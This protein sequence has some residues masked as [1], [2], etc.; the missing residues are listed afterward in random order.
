MI[1]STSLSPTPSAGSSTF[2][3]LRQYLIKWM[4]MLVYP[5]SP[6]QSS[7]LLI[8]GLSLIPKGTRLLCSCV[9]N[10]DCKGLADRMRESSLDLL[11]RP[12]AGHRRCFLP[13][14]LLQQCLSGTVPNC[15]FQGRHFVTVLMSS[16]EAGLS[17]CP[18]PTKWPSPL[19]LP[20]SDSSCF[21]LPTRER[22]LSLSFN[23]GI[24]F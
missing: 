12:R 8:A 5:H 4:T 18:W 22:G 24:V 23:K 20:K 10:V 14:V 21:W 19:F 15:H 16:L 6:T 3:G 9:L 2:R 13:L 1:S 11:Y 17:L 7:S